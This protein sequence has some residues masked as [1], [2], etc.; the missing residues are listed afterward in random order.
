MT[1]LLD[2]VETTPA[3]QQQE[4][5]VFLVQD[6]ARLLRKFIEKELAKAGLGITPSGARV[7][8]YSL[9]FPGLRQ[10]QLAERMSLDP[11]TLVG[12]LDILE[13]Q[14]L[15]ERKPDPEDR[16]CN[17][18]A[19]TPQAMELLKEVKQVGLK[20]QAQAYGDLSDSELE[21]AYILLKKMRDNLL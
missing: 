20:A 15:V 14:K 16:R 17:I 1:N 10:N 8:F 7:L 19:L 11:M 4:S 12:H 9:A 18:V 6:L 21:Q 5:Y 2:T 3:A 13:E